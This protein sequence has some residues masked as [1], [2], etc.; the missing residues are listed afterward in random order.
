MADLTLLQDQFENI[1]QHTQHGIDFCDR[2]GN[3]LKE[4]CSIENEYAAKLKYVT[5]LW[6]LLID[7]RLTVYNIGTVAAYCKPGS[8]I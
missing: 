4:R 2:V 6:L 3:F 7:L 5:T 8:S 1:A